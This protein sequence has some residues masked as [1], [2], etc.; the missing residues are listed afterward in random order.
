MHVAS[1]VVDSLITTEGPVSYRLRYTTYQKQGKFVPLLTNIRNIKS[2]IASLNVK[3]KISC[4]C[5]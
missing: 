1:V 5:L 4:H 3:E 2:V